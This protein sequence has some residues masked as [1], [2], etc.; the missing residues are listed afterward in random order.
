[1]NGFVMGLSGSGDE[2]LHLVVPGD[3]YLLAGRGYSVQTGQKDFEAR[4]GPNP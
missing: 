3:R 4:V 2:G 1:M